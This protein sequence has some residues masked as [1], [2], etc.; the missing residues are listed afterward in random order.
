LL[1]DKGGS[2]VKRTFPEYKANRDAT[3]EAIKIFPIFKHY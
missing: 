2:A 3:P 1:F